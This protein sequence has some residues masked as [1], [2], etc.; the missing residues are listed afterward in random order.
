MSN[1]HA[2]YATT[3][4]SEICCNAY[5]RCESVQNRQADN[6][7]LRHSVFTFVAREKEDLK[8]PST[9][10]LAG[11]FSPIHSPEI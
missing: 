10:G 3:I 1:S 7:V 8:S 5:I 6:T 9:M 11:R 4:N 2:N